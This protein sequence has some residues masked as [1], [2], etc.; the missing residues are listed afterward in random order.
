[1]RIWSSVPTAASGETAPSTGR[2][3]GSSP[4]LAVKRAD[5]PSGVML[6]PLPGWWQLTHAR[7]LPKGLKKGLLVS[8]APALLT[9][10]EAPSS[11][12]TGASGTAADCVCASTDCVCTMVSVLVDAEEVTPLASSAA[13]LA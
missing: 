6:Q 4:A 11:F 8:I 5:K 7:P 2:N 10:S 3:T 13:D 1:M 12:G 9:V